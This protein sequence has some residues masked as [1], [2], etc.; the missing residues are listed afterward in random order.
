MIS[1]VIDWVWLPDLNTPELS[2]PPAPLTSTDTSLAETDACIIL[3]PSRRPY[4][5][6]YIHRGS[7]T[8][9]AAWHWQGL[10]A[11]AIRARYLPRFFL[12]GS[13]AGATVSREQVL[14]LF[15]CVASC[16]GAG[17]ST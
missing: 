6:S 16:R 9:T 15:C 10:P 8:R 7:L 4:V 12:D 5:C 3:N 14:A 1:G 17:G 13:T 2:F 11:L